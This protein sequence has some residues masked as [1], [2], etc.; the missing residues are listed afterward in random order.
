MQTA[1]TFATPNVVP[2]TPS[3]S[4]SHLAIFPTKFTAPRSSPRYTPIKVATFNNDTSTESTVDYSS[5]Y[6]VFPAEACETIGGDACMAEMYPEVKL[7]PESKND[8]PKV[9]TENVDREYLEYNDPKTV[10]RAEA[11]DDL[12]GTFCEHEYQKSVY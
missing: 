9:A 1:L 4:V 10:F 3:K 12:G 11:C 2:L 6:S 8:T 5:A 7:Q